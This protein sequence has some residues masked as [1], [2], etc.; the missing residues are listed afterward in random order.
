MAIVDEAEGVRHHSDVVDSLD[1]ARPDLDERYS[2]SC[3]R[4]LY[5]KG[6]ERSWERPSGTEQLV[7]TDIW[8]G[9]YPN[10]IRPSGTAAR[11]I[12]YAF[13]DRPLSEY[14]L[15]GDHAGPG[16]AVPPYHL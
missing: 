12:L 4:V 7:I 11:T 6:E 14:M 3:H 8:G 1:P 16:M 10:S 5:V 9:S 15:C 13:D 2:W